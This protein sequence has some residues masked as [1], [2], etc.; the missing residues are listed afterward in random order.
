[1]RLPMADQ[2][3][4]IARRNTASTESLPFRFLIIKTLCRDDDISM[5]PIIFP[6]GPTLDRNS[7]FVCAS[8]L[9]PAFLSEKK[10]PVNAANIG[11]FHLQPQGGL[12]SFP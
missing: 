7:L 2:W 11:F 10:E 6:N 4:T 12:A 3:L 1:M 8:P 5:L 9:S